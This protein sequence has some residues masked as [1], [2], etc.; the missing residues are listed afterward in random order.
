MREI[1]KLGL[2]LLLICSVAAVVLGLTNSLT[3]DTI[4]EVEEQLSS[5]AR[6]EVLQ[7]SDTDRVESID[8]EKLKSI[9]AEDDKVLEVYAG[10]AGDNLVGYAIKTVDGSGYGGNI[11]VITGIS[12]DGDVIAIKVVTHQETPGLGANATGEGFQGQ[13][14]GKDTEK[15]IVRVKTAPAPDSNEIQALSGATITSDSVIRAVN[16]A[17]E[18]FNNKLSK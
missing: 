6:K 18:V 2:I 3:K 14:A 4:V 10:Y 13:F 5:E 1:I 9:Q 7:L 8:E 15:E 17:R 12:I 11:E 16:T